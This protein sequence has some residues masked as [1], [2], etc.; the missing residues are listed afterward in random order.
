M[1]GTKQKC[2]FRKSIASYPQLVDE[3]LKHVLI[4]GASLW[5][6]IQNVEGILNNTCRIFS[7]FHSYRINITCTFKMA[8]VKIIC[9]CL[10][11]HKKN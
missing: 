4:S 8:Y 7:K 11:T 1:F 5:S 2:S 6:Y 10:N 3:R 9:I